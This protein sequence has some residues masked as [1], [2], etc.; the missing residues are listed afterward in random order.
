[1]KLSSFLAFVFLLV[2]F[3]SEA[4][5]EE[6]G[7]IS[8]GP[9]AVPTEPSDTGKQPPGR[10][11]VFFPIEQQGSRPKTSTPVQQKPWI[12][13]ISE[14]EFDF[15]AIRSIVAKKEKIFVNPE[16]GSI[17]THTVDILNRRITGVNELKIP[18]ELKQAPIESTGVGNL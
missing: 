13:D 8:G 18:V 4:R 6:G 12:L 10:G 1:M 3:G 17:M 11:G 5:S 15:L 9:N 16:I 7:V 14:D 2:G